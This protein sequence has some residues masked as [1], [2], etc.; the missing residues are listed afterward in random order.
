M[1]R[2]RKDDLAEEPLTASL[3]G[4]VELR[5]GINGTA[6]GA[7]FGLAIRQQVRGWRLWLFVVLFALPSGMAVV[8][9]N[10]NRPPESVVLENFLVYMLFPHV[11]LP[12]A[13]LLNAS[14][15]VQDEVEGQTL[16]YLLVRPLPRG[17]IY[18]TKLAAALVVTV[19]LTVIFVPPTVLAIYAGPGGPPVGM[20]IL[21]TVGVFALGVVAYC[22]VFGCLSLFAQRFL[23]AGIG[24]IILFEGVLAN[25]PI[26]LR[27][28]TLVYY[29]RVLAL[30]WAGANM[31]GW[32]MS[33]EEIPS[34]ATAVLVLVLVSVVA[35]AL[36]ARA[37]AK[38]EFRMKTPEGS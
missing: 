21:Q 37:F 30:R 15:M 34:A 25:V 33:L 36:A 29:Q 38:R 11:L 2:A 9:R 13:A 3:A 26:V 27:Q 16:T 14:A 7:L 32:N 22:S 19:G 1:K 5:H 8:A 35:T 4:P 20:R 23:V 6:L 18:L 28:L 12:L 10:L 24:Y 17:A 31:P